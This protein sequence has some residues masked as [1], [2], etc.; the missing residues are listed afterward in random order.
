MMVALAGLGVGLIVENVHAED[1][2]DSCLQEY[3]ELA[4]VRQVCE[5]ECVNPVYEQY[6]CM[7]WCASQYAPE[8][9]GFNAMAIAISYCCGS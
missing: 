3:C 6:D 4:D 5:S 7:N 8:M 1:D 9:G 2:F